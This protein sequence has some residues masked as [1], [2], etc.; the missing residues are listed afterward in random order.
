MISALTLQ[1]T[2]HG[3]LVP[4]TVEKGHQDFKTMQTSYISKRYAEWEIN[5]GPPDI[6]GK[7]AAGPVKSTG[8]WSPCPV[9]F[10]ILCM[11]RAL[12]Q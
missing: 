10:C 9:K 11:C 7:S 6:T 8:H 12:N 3:W 5:T 4:A 1:S 2:R